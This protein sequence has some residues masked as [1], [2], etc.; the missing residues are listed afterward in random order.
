MTPPL[1]NPV[2]LPR[3]SPGA[4][5]GAA[6]L[7]WGVAI[8]LAMV[9]AAQQ[10]PV[11]SAPW[12]KQS[13]TVFFCASLT[14]IGLS[15]C[16]SVE[17]GWRWRR[18][19]HCCVQPAIADLVCDVLIGAVMA[20]ALVRGEQSRLLIAGLDRLVSV[21]LTISIVLAAMWLIDLQASRRLQNGGA[22]TTGE[23]A[24]RWA[25]C[26]LALGVAVLAVAME[27][28]EW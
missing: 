7:A 19:S 8:F 24:L 28:V 17:C 3:R 2:D 12:L 22:A 18:P 27:S 15:G 11:D 25:R 1:D 6:H 20:A 23:R 10:L 13:A 16:R 26:A 21:M 9:Y 4:L 14:W 5:W